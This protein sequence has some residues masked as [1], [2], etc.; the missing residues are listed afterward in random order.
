[1]PQPVHYSHRIEFQFTP[2]SLLLRPKLAPHIA[3]ISA[4]WNDIE[5]RIGALLASLVGS[6][7]ETVIS[8]F[9]AVK[10]DAARRATINTVVE[11]KM[12]DAERER[13]QAIMKDVGKRCAER[14]AIVHNAWG[15]SPLYPNDLLWCDIR[16]T[17]MLHADMMSVAP[18]RVDARMVEEQ[19]KMMV[20][21]E[22]DFI[23]IENR[24]TATYD[25]LRAFSKP[26]MERGL[27][28]RAKVDLPPKW[29][30]PE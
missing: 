25:E 29:L 19:R 4:M 1:M 15:I 6:E 13:F 17:M 30:P 28:P 7:A 12:S 26:I 10:N 23:A 27:G 3:V 16:E 2:Q 24:I 18:G 8:I 21:R 11:L 14:N 9:L 22:D 20:Y 5:A